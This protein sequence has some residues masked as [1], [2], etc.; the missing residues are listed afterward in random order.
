MNLSFFIGLLKND[1]LFFQGL[2]KFVIFHKTIEIIDFLKDRKLFF[3]SLINLS[4]FIGPL[5][6]LISWRIENYF[7]KVYINL[8]FFIGPLK[9]DKLFFQGLH[10]FV[11]FHKTIEIIDFLKDIKLFISWRIEIIFKVSWICHFS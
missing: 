8:S 2:Y 7:F 6:L 9:N 1:K 11:I 10:K 5:K 3:Q 4:F